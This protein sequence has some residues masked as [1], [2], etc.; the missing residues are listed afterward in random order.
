MKGRDG[1]EVGAQQFLQ[2]AFFNM[3]DAVVR[4]LGDLEGVIGFEVRVISLI[5]FRVYLVLSTAA[6]TAYERAS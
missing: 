1:K 2:D 3:Y 4:A 5:V 6:H